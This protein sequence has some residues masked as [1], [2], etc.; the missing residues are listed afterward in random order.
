MVREVCHPSFIYG[1]KGI[2][3]DERIGWDHGVFVPMLLI[4][5]KADIPIIQVSVLS[6]DS[7]AQHFA[8]GQALAPLRDSNIAIVGS[9]SPSFH[10]FRLMFRGGGNDSGFKNRV[11][12]WNYRL[13][14]TMKTED[15]GERGKALESYRQWVG[16]K[17]AHPDGGV[18][19]FLPLVVCAGAAGEGKAEAFED[20]MWEVKES[21][22]YWT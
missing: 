8:M 6:S 21:T 15:V 19:H 9:G 11:K 13:T 5:P 1:K 22:Y 10:N 7:P 4:N 3:S 2:Y 16:A 20:A 12:E 17:D 18:E 14:E